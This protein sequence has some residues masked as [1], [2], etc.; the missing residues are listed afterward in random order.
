MW[1]VAIPLKEPIGR[2]CQLR[3]RRRQVSPQ[4]GHEIATDRFRL[5]VCTPNR[6]PVAL[7]PGTNVGAMTDIANVTVELDA[8]DVARSVSA[9]P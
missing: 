9:R 1:A 5:R 2:A 7:E 3:L 6:D 8:G 4:H